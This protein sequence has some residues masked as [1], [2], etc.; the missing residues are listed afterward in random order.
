MPEQIRIL[1]LNCGSSSLKFGVFS[2]DEN[3]LEGEAEEIGSAHATFWY[4]PA[5]QPKQESSKDIETHAAAF[6]LVQQTLAE[7]GLTDYQAI[8]H[9]VVHGGPQL[10]DH[11][12]LTDE[13]LLDLK[14]A[15]PFAPLHLPASIDVIE[16][17]SKSLPDLPQIICLDTAFHKDL[18]DVSKTLPFSHDVRAQGVERFGFHGLSLESIVAQLPGIPQKLVIAHLGNGASITALR[19]GKSIDTS[20]GLTPTG[21]I[22]MGT[23]CGDVDPGALLYLLQQGMT[24]DDLVKL[25]DHQSGLLGIS[26]KTSD[27]RELTNAR[28][29]DSKC[30]LALRMFAYQVRKTVA[31]MA[32]SLEGL[33]LLIFTGGIG[34]HAD[35]IRKEV[36]TSLSF[37]GN[38]ETRTLPAEED[39][40]IARITQRLL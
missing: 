9:R 37:L 17:V 12:R 2:G 36:T 7:A 16:A 31:A 35:N 38:F 4:S 27:V 3:L 6:N 19:K 40:Q 10:R 25:V 20:M 18:P 34:E 26:E 29:S 15:M 24:E 23:R 14:K 39:L 1:S 33:D 28:A 5:G 8:G 22:M 11:F 30:D 32:A 13:T 21:G